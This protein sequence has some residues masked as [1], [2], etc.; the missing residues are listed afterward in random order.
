[1]AQ[2][3]LAIVG[4]D[5]RSLAPLE[6]LRYVLAFNGEIYNYVE[7]ADRLEVRPTSDTAVLLQGFEIEGR[8]FLDR[9]EGFWSLALFDKLWG[10]VTLA[11]DAMG[12]RPLYWTRLDGGLVASST[13][14][15]LLERLR[16]IKPTL[17]EAALSDW[18]RYQF[19][20]D[21]RST[22]FEGIFRLAPGEILQFDPS[23][24]GE[25]YPERLAFSRV[26]DQQGDRPLD[27]Q[28]VREAREVLRCSIASASTGDRAVTSTCSGGLDSS[29][30]T[31]MAEPS[32][33]YHS[34]FTDPDCNETQ[35]A[36]AALE[37]SPTRLMVVNAREHFDLVARLDGLV[38]DF[39]E[40]TVGSV[41]L[42]LENLFAEV[43]RRYRVVLLGTGGDELFGGY[44]RYA[45]AMGECPDD[46]YRA[47][48]DR[49]KG[50]T[51]GERFEEL[52]TK[53]NPSLFAFDDGKA[54]ERL[55][56]ALGPAPTYGDL[57]DFDRRRFLP[58][59][60]N[61]DDKIAGRFGLEGRPALLHQAFV[62]K[63]LELAPEAS[64]N[65][66]A[67]REIARGIL[68]DSVIDRTDKMGF[69]TPIGTFVDA[70]ASRI[71]ETLHDSRFHDLYH[72]DRVRFTSESKWSRDL[73][74]LV[75]LDC[76]LRRYA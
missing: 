35:W 42:P 69:T 20:L 32:V 3:R 53:G 19:V 67:L 31:R 50:E 60:L 56:M 36:K 21:P 25:R 37:G 4:L 15:P 6:G 57:V 16:P 45:M 59:L 55:R 33:A 48:F 5:D 44:T 2:T 1:M 12:V 65:K 26:W 66:L 68:P 23:A 72:L 75:L 28:W 41:I 54:R 61:I 22:F 7:L 13:L 73:F 38:E 58:A 46:H 18:A 10:Q 34:N 24:A 71:R 62:R 9:C 74:G 64:P 11:R 47:A 39:D 52:H 29:L 40:L 70:S 63:A 14:A 43:A 49:L 51:P 76:W 17:N 30:V 8:T 27:A